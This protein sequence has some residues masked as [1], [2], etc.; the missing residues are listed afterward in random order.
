[1]PFTISE[2]VGPYQIMEQLGQG[3]MAIVYRA[4]HAALNRDIAIKVLNIDLGGNPDFIERFKREA[5]VIAQLDDPHIVPIYSIGDHNGLP[6]LT[7]KYI[8]GQTLKDSIKDSPLPKTEILRVVEAIGNGLQYA[9]ER[10]IVHRDIKPSN[11]LI[12][13]DGRIYL[14]DFGLAKIIAK[15][16]KLT[17]DMIVGTPHYMSPEQ[18]TG[19]ENLDARTDIYSLGVMIYE[20]VTGR[21]PFDAVGFQS[22]IQDHIF[23]PVPLPTTIK[24]DLPVEVE[25]VLLKALSKQR[26]D[27]YANT[28][29]LVLDFRQ[30]WISNA[31]SSANPLIGLDPLLGRAALYAENG[32]SFPLI[33]GTVILGRSNSAQNNM[34]DIDISELD[35]SKITSRRH[36][37]IQ[38]QD[39]SFLILDLNSKNGIFLNGKHIPPQKPCILSSGDILEFG[40]GGVKLTFFK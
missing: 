15:S 3:G 5:R 24:P 26:N 38:F 18:A 13:N 31:G 6:Y 40:K 37:M 34:N 17:G 14:S 20:L 33:S 2:N 16:S 39:D 1:M 36:A 4:Y 27:R 29:D 35:A 30:A 9:H 21:L 10:G 8:D 32:K 28:K 19:E 23:A 25:Y 12:A 22:I 7:L 11:I